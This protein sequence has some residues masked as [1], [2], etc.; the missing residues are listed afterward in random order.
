MSTAWIQFARSMERS[1]RLRVLWALL[2]IGVCGGIALWIEPSEAKFVV[3]HFGYYFT[4]LASLGCVLYGAQLLRAVDW[5]QFKFSRIWPMLVSVFIGC[6]VLFSQADFGYKIAMDDYLLTQTAKS[7]H[8]TREV[9]RTEFGRPIGRDFVALEVEVDKRP[10]LYPFVVASLHDLVGYRTANPFIVNALAAVLFLVGAYFFGHHLAGCWAGVSAVLL[11]AGLPLLAQNATG[12]GMEM[13]N[14][15]LLQGVLLLAVYYL[16]RPSRAAEG[17]LSLMM[18]LLAYTR[19]ESGLF[20]LPVALVIIVGW[21]REGRIFLSWGTVLAAPLLMGLLLQTQIY[22]VSESAW[23]LNGEAASPFGVEALLNN[24]PHALYFFFSYTHNLANSLLLSLLGIP[25][26]L[27]FYVMLRTELP[28]YWRSN[29][30]GLITSLFGLFLL[31]HLLFVLS[32]HASQFDS[33]YVSRYALPIHWL[34]ISS[35][36]ALLG[37]MTQRRPSVWRYVIGLAVIFILS[38]SLP[39]NSKAIFSRS[40]FLVNER[41]W[42]EELSEKGFES[43]SLVVDRF[44]PSWAL[45]EQAALEPS[46]ALLNSDRI[47]EEVTVG[48]YPAV[49]LVERMEYR[50][51]KFVPNLSEFEQLRERWPV[52]LYTERSFQ[53]FEL[54]RVYRYAPTVVER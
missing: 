50:A 45:L 10:W 36:I 16:Q 3:R 42:L 23:E 27:A 31:L 49:Y 19:Y 22:A 1:I 44:F 25:A 30:A 24:I 7:L 34:F 32:F 48:K 33:P 4:L 37:Y 26:V 43:S 8:E 39:M 2:A 18:V 52:E 46:V 35:L 54:T 38:F 47:R 17:A 11:W 15:L 51:G 14:L 5:G 41:N 12:A 9:A 6:W 21:W 40:N 53:P 28:K 13:L 29:P 20:V